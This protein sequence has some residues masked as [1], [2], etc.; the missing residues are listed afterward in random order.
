MKSSALLPVLALAVAAL[1]YANYALMNLPV[2]TSP[3]APPAGA[4]DPNA[5]ASKDLGLNVPV[6]TIAEFPQTA[7]R[8]VFFA[9]RKIPERARPKPVAIAEA[10]EPSPPPP[11]PLEP[12][13]LVG[14][15]GSGAGK[16]ALVKGAADPQ[17]TWLAVG[18]EFRGWQLRDITNDNAIVEARGQRSE[19]RLYAYGGGKNVKR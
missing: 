13:Q 1:G 3:V 7:T 19:L 17:A 8:P 11:A 15:M 12:L 18:D 9:D 14:I 6:R 16:R 2:E 10:K 5:A 4:V